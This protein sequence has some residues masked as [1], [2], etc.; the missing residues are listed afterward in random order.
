MEL[1]SINHKLKQLD[2][3]KTSNKL[4]VFIFEDD[5]LKNKLVIDHCEVELAYKQLL[6]SLYLFGFNK[7]VFN[8]DL[9]LYKTITNLLILKIIC[10]LKL[11]MEN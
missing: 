4:V 1:I 8:G 9:N 6:S 10:F 3:T 2:K 5:V 7:L 11:F